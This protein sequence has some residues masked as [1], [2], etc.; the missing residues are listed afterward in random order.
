MSGPDRD[1][2]GSLRSISSGRP[3]RDS[4]FFLQRS[5]GK[6]LLVHLPSRPLPVGCLP[7]TASRF[8]SR[9]EWSLLRH[10]SGADH[11]SIRHVRRPDLGPGVLSTVAL[12]GHSPPLNPCNTEVPSRVYR[13]RGV[14]GPLV[15]EGVGLYRGTEQR[16]QPLKRE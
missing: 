1:S 3:G 7:S 9:I 8:G 11:G 15:G 6:G 16:Q 10:K 12:Q 5:P 4:H 14:E 2:V 13:T